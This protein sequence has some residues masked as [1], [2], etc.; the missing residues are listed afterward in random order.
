MRKRIL[1]IAMALCLIITLLPAT[2]LA[3]DAETITIGGET[4]SGS[5]GSPAYAATDAAT[6]AVTKQESAEGATITWD[7]SML[8]LNNATIKGNSGQGIVYRDG[9]KKMME[10]VPGAAYTSTAASLS[11]AAAR[12]MS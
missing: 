12:L 5:E 10:I 9:A 8:T 6:G 1:A 7:G 11:R 2:A 4:L 3:A